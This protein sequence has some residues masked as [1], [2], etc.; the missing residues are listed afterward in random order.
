MKLQIIAFFL[1]LTIF[2]CSAWS[3][4]PLRP[5]FA[6][7]APSHSRLFA[8]NESLVPV[9]KKNIENAAA[10]TG[11]ILGFVLAGPVGGLVFAAVS[12]YLAK[13]E[14]DAGDALRGVGKTVVESYNY[15]TKLNLK[16]DL[17]GQ[18]SNVI[19]SALSSVETESESLAT[20]KKTYT[21]ATEKLGELNKEYDLVGKGKDVISAAAALS[22]TALEKVV[23]LNKEYDFVDVAK[24]VASQGV[25]KLKEA[26]DKPTA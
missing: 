26:T 8:D 22:E 1:L 12:N 6:I 9:D 16:Y 7:K 11:G 4:R 2:S 21:T 17:T 23:E 3:V 25:A 18:A 14:S 10:V 5:S 24:K 13:R 15:L 20:V 19:G